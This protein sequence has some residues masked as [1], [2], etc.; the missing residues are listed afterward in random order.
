MTGQ[1][2][3]KRL[4][5]TSFFR[6]LGAVQRGREATAEA[7]KSPTYLSKSRFVEFWLRTDEAGGL[8]APE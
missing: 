5:K 8:G 4:R 3:K 7:P 1:A 6:C 2:P